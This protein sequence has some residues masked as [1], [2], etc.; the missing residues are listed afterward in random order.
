MKQTVVDGDVQLDNGDRFK[1]RT[2]DVGGHIQVDDNNGPSKL[3]KNRVQ[4][5]TLANDNDGGLKIRKNKVGGNLQCEGN[6]P[7]PTGGKNW[8]EGDKVGQCSS[9]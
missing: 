6:E 1:V 3:A 5:D 2:A 8:V 4:G 9:L 7:P